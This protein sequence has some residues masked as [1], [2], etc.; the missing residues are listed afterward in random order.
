MAFPFVHGTTA[1]RGG[2]RSIHIDVIPHSAQRYILPFILFQ[3]TK[4]SQVNYNIIVFL[5][6]LHVSEPR[7]HTFSIVQFCGGTCLLDNSAAPG[8]TEFRMLLFGTIAALA[9]FLGCDLFG[10][11]FFLW[12]DS[13]SATT[14]V[15]LC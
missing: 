9:V 11:A 6:T 2:S 3:E 15:G 8:N 1:G 5:L 13:L 10:L 4:K 14:A 7:V 12:S